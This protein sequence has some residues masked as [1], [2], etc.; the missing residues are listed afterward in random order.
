M[1]NTYILQKS[2][3]DNKKY[4]VTTPPN[5][6][7][8][9]TKTIHFGA[10]G[11]S[12]YTIHK[13]YDRMLRYENRHHSRENWSKNGINTPGWWSKW[14]LWNLPSLN[15]SIKNTEKRFKIKIKYIR[16]LKD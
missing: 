4:M 3:K 12:D 5:P 6:N 11:M 10:S 8:G 1:N 7:T 13:D 14:I 9:R 16:N 15:S 2:N